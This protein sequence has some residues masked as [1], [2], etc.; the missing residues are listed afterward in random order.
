[1]HCIPFAFSKCFMHLDV[2][3]YVENCVLIDLDWVKPMMQFF[4]TYHMFMH[5]SCIV[6]FLFYLLVL[7][8]DGAFLFVSLSLSLSLSLIVYA[9]HRSIN[10]LHLGT[11]FVLGHL[12]LILL[13]FTSV[14][15]WEGPSRLLKE[16]LQTWHS[17]KMSHDS[18]ELFRYYFTH[19]HS[20]LGMR[21][22]MWDTCELSHHNH[23]G[24]LLQYA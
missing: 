14:S 11:L 18:I 10:L 13:H 8:Y 9:W 5:F 7:Y 12:P 20:Q 21:I 22:S 6:P 16:L 3:L 24:V 23:I 15:W 2:C 4:F 19:C 17:F 1:M